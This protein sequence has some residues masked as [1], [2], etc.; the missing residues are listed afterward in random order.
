MKATSSKGQA[1]LRILCLLGIAGLAA[2]AGMKFSTA[3]AEDYRYSSRYSY[4][5][6]TTTPT[7]PPPPP[8]A[9]HELTTADCRVCHP[10]EVTNGRANNPLCTDQG[11]CTSAAVLQLNSQTAC[12]ITAQEHHQL[13]CQP[14][15]ITGKTYGCL[16]CHLL[17]PPPDFTP[18]VE[19]DCLNCHTGTHTSTDHFNRHGSYIA[20]AENHLFSG[21]QPGTAPLWSQITQF[22]YLDRFQVTQQYQ[23]CY[24]CHSYNGFGAAPNGVSQVVSRSNVNLT[25]QAME[26]NPNNRSAHP[27]QVALNSQTG[28]YAPKALARTQM[29][30]QWQ[31][32]GVQTMKCSDCHEAPLTPGSVGPQGSA[33]KFLLKGPRVYWPYNRNGKLWTLAD[34]RSS[35]SGWSTDLFCVNCHPLYSGR[36]EEGWK[37]NVHGDDEHYEESM[38]IGGIRYNG[39]PCVSCHVAV[40]HGFRIS[41]LIGYA[42]DP[43]PYST[44]QPN[45]TKAQVL[46]GFRK[47]RSPF[48]YDEDNCYSTVGACD[49][50]DEGRSSSFDPFV[51]SASRGDD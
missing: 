22:T 48:S 49:E 5:G 41:R 19:R 43:V 42:G 50:H 34:V 44:L 23:V 3:H 29:T 32:V 27:V 38:T 13:L 25:D 20:N 11:L 1:T 45:G 2:T 26:F 47:A 4:W 16:D 14:S 7:P 37:N 39:A 17:G 10:M 8:P 35:T 21:V 33:T 31:G 51:T 6:T 40:P 24:K 30:A 46:K 18:T 36:G 9:V 12:R 28:S 15:P